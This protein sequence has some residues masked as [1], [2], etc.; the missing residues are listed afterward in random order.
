MP[1]PNLTPSTAI[2]IAS[3]PFSVTIDPEMQYAGG[4]YKFTPVTNQVISAYGCNTLPRDVNV[5]IWTGNDPLNLNYETTQASKRPQVWPLLA[6][7]DVY[8]QLY[9]NDYVTGDDLSLAV[10]NPTNTAIQAGDILITEDITH[11]I[12][13]LY[14]PTFEGFWPYTWYSPAG[15]LRKTDA[16]LPGS[17]IGAC[18]ANGIY[19][20]YC[21]DLGKLFIYS[22]LSIT[23]IGRFA[24]PVADPTQIVAMAT[25]LTY[26]YLA[27]APNGTDPLEIYR[28]TQAGVVTGPIAT[29]DHY[30]SCTAL[31]SGGNSSCGIARDVSIF[32][33]PES[34]VA[35]G[36]I[37]RH[38]INTATELAKFNS[39]HPTLKI[40]DVI[41]LSDGTVCAIFGDD[42]TITSETYIVQYSAA[43]AVLQN[44]KIDDFP[45]RPHHICH[46]PDDSALRIWT[47]TQHLS[48]NSPANLSGY[49]KFRLTTLSTG[50]NVQNF[51][52]GSFI[53]GAG[54]YDNTDTCTTERFGAP[55]SCPFFV[56]MS[57]ASPPPPG[58]DLSGI[59][60]IDPTKVTRHD[61][62]YGDIENKIPN[63]TIR[64]AYLGE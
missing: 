41:V 59:Y 58:G 18:L 57:S 54:P 42:G 60:F 17:E 16:T 39:P 8:F 21:W 4:W 51:T 26:F 55:D 13:N 49:N 48:T 20:I 32:Y 2:T 53:R 43:G 7:T 6:G 34:D 31:G 25:D 45:F 62:Y 22:A 40:G 63:P 38:N 15:V 12:P 27:Y 3:L 14:D 44:R 29:V 19:G 23:E 50:A 11:G 9:T 47:W 28:V 5:E 10:T 64:T 52:K 35:G 37:R 46:P 36:G 56:M 61:S 24:I 30:S 33:Y 1:L